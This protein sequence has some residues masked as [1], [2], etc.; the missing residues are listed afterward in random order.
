MTY[1]A[2]DQYGHTEHNL[3]DHP[4]RELLRRMC[5]KSARKMY[6]DKKNGSSAHIGWIV[7]GHW[8]TVFHVERMERPA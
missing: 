8:F 6:V 2:I 4:R 7:A 1:M 5:R 3:G